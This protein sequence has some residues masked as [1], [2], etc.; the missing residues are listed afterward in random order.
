MYADNFV[1]EVFGLPVELH[2]LGAQSLSYLGREDFVL[3]DACE[4]LFDSFGLLL[5]QLNGVG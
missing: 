3:K 4:G 2:V 1:G 5:D